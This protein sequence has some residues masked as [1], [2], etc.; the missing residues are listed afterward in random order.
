MSC[1]DVPEMKKTS[2][3]VIAGNGRKSFMIRIK[4]TEASAKAIKCVMYYPDPSL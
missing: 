1:C 2:N 3:D 4:F